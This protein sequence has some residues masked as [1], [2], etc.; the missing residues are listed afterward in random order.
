[1]TW[2]TEFKMLRWYGGNSA[3]YCHKVK[4]M[5]ALVFLHAPQAAGQTLNSFPKLTYLL[6]YFFPIRRFR[7]SVIFPAPLK[8]SRIHFPTK[9]GQN[10]PKNVLWIMKKELRE[11]RIRTLLKWTILSSV[12]FVLVGG[13]VVMIYDGA[14]SNFQRLMGPLKAF[15][16]RNIYQS[17]S[18]SSFYSRV[19]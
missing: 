13:K 1:M 12:D 8:M 11:S 3:I 6:A 9:L 4:E 2:W 17:P 14:V 10:W 16:Y 18:C 7:P 5:S 19:Y 15:Y